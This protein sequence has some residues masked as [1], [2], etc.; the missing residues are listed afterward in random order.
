MKKAELREQFLAK[1][2]ALSEQAVNEASQ[3]ICQ[4]LFENV[5]YAAPCLAKAVHVFLPIRRQNEVNTWPIIQHLWRDPLTPRVIVSVSKRATNQLTHYPLTP[6]THLVENHWGIPEPADL[7]P[8]AVNS[9]SLDVVLVPL[10][11]FDRRG[12]RVGYGRGYYDRFLAECRPDCYKVGLS[13]FEPVAQIVD[14]EPTDVRLDA[15]VT[16]AQTYRF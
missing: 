7:S 10:L 2:R 16:P 5:I 11:A 8:T 12:H 13:T 3:Q 4:R 6:S 9:E 1:R 15:C 14:V